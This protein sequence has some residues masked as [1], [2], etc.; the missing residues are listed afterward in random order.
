[1]KTPTIAYPHGGG[2]AWLVNLIWQLENNQL[3]LNTG[4]IVVFDNLPAAKSI[5]TTH[6][7]ELFD[8][9]TPTYIYKGDGALIKFSSSRWFNLFITEAVKVRYHL[10]H[11]GEKTILEQFYSLTDSAVYMLTNDLYRSTWGEPVDLNYALIFEDSDQF[12]DQLFAILDNFSIKYTKDRDHCLRSIQHYKSTCP[13]TQDHLG[14]F[15]SL[16]WLSWVHAC[17]MIN[18][19]SLPATVTEGVQV[20]DIRKIV[21]PVAAGILEYTRPMTINWK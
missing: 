20:A 14:N 15:D 17:L 21:E 5:H 18:G 9:V 4:P 3:T 10:L 7:Y 6:I 13:T 12:I 19:K 8:N 1:M 2:G 11:L 16:L